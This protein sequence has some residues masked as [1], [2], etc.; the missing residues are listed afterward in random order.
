MADDNDYDYGKNKKQNTTVTTINYANQKELIK[1]EDRIIRYIQKE[2]T[3]AKE[4]FK[5]EAITS[6]EIITKQFQDEI[7]SLKDQYLSDKEKEYVNADRICRFLKDELAAG[8]EFI[9]KKF[10]DEVDSLKQQLL[11]LKEEKENEND[12][13]DDDVNNNDDYDDDDN[14][15]DGSV[16]DDIILEDETAD[17][18]YYK[19]WEKNY[20]V[21]K[22]YVSKNDGKIPTYKCEVDGIKIGKFVQNQRAIYNFLKSNPGQRCGTGTMSNRRKDGLEKIESWTWYL[23]KNA[24]KD[25]GNIEDDD[26]DE[27]EAEVVEEEEDGSVGTVINLEDEAAD[28]IFYKKWKKNYKLL[29]KYVDDNDGKIPTFGCEVDG[30]T[31]GE[32]VRKQ[33]YLYNFYRN[34]PGQRCC[35]GMMSNRRKDDL[36]RIESWTWKV[37]EKE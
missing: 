13:D 11:L 2:V 19:K 17:N 14:E 21:L 27:A 32:W 3:T 30:I 6:K 15:G 18:S 34:H 9:T 22:K 16:V 5:K 12:N 26:E 28:G 7:K 24:K 29:K 25:N 1:R 10:Q 37:Y 35:S 31:L 23:K 20:K 36:E 4:E 8:K 33:R